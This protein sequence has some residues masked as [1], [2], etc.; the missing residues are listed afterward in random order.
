M[1]IKEI[2]NKCTYGTQG[3][4][5]SQEDLYKVEELIIY[6]LDIIDQ[7]KNVIVATNYDG[8]WKEANREMWSKY[9]ADVTFIDL[10]KNRGYSHGYL[11]GINIIL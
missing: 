10:D 5:T 3:Y 1:N 8:D 6:N 2:I 7:F 11:H 4:I 9:F